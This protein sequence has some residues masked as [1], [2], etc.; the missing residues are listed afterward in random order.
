[1]ST[2]HQPSFWTHYVFSTD[3]KMIG[4]QYYFTAIF[5]ALFATAWSLLLRVHLAWPGRTWPL[6]GKLFPGLFQDGVLLPE[7][8]LSLV[9]MHGTV[10]IFFVVSIALVSGFGNFII[11]L[12]IGARD[13]AYPFLNMLSYWTI[14]PAC[15]LMLGSFFVPDG[16]AASGWTAYPPLSAIPEASPGSGMGQ[17]LWLFAMALFIASFTM[18]GLNFVTTILNLRTRGMSMMRMPLMIWTLFVASVLG[19]LAFPALT[20]A[21]IMLLLDRLGS[22]SFF[23]PA[24][25]VFSGTV[26]P[27][28]GGTPLLFQ[29]LFWFLGHPEVYVLVLPALGIAFEVIAVFGRRP[30]FGYRTSVWAL[31]VIA[32]LSMIVWGHHMFVSGMSPYVGEYFSVATVTITAPFAILAMNLIASLWRAEIRLSPALLFVLGIIAAVGIGGLGGIFLAT[33]TSDQYLHNS[34]FVVGHFHLMIAVVTMFAIFAGTYH[35]FPKMF[36]RE[37]NATLGKVH[38]WLTVPTVIVGFVGMHL[39]GVGGEQRHLYDPT[40]Y[41]FL[42]PLQWLNVVITLTLGGAAAAQLV[43]LGNFFSSLFF[44]ARAGANPWEATTLEWTT[45]SPA[46]HGNWAHELPMVHREPY[47]YRV[48]RSP[49]GYDPQNAAPTA[50]PAMA[51]R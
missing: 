13:M 14:V 29:H 12:Q 49:Q 34:Y 38:F 37:M 17:T 8:Y 46:P 11:P 21:A 19:I 44:G 28:S 3:H 43:F 39:L 16:A 1:M 35:W 41:E 36:G 33:A 25:L 30:V 2:T 24:G 4:K 26:L 42:K 47:E 9:T 50:Q 5:M 10:M 32:V 18:G 15:L 27:H 31:L 40:A 22:T 6:F 48:G 51:A 20:A 45:E 23:L 7:R